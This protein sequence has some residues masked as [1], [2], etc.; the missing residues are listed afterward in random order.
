MHRDELAN[1]LNCNL[2]RTYTRVVELGSI[3]KAAESL[4]LAQSAV[5][6]HVATLASF[7]G[8]SL[9]ER[10][11]GRLVPTALGS[12]L[13]TGAL[14]ILSCVNDLD[15]RLQ[16]MAAQN[17]RVITVACTRTVC[18]TAVAGI[19]AAFQREFPEYR[20]SIVPATIKDAEGRLR[21]G[22]IDAALTEGTNEIPSTRRYAFR[23]DRLMLA[24]PRNHDL[25]KRSS[26]TIAEA[27]AYPFILRT[28]SSG[29]RA[30]IEER[31]G[32]R[33]EQLRVVLELEGNSE[34]VSC[35]EAGIGVSL[36]SQGALVRAHALGSVIVV[37][38]EDVDF[39]RE[40]H[41]ALPEE[42][43]TSEATNAFAKWLLESYSRSFQETVDASSAISI[44]SSRA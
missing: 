21:S 15:R 35:V 13:Y 3:T 43:E 10:R 9:F 23:K 28:R 7:A 33:F 16:H 11:E 27:S 25:A 30:L 42:R 1:S 41:L 4:Y 37:G 26:V 32:R 39:E 8:G 22:E 24:V 44:L 20:L 36:L 34:I 19:V 2:L 40:F 14:G 18:E 6:S 31:L 5:S 38:V 12:E 29:T 17:A